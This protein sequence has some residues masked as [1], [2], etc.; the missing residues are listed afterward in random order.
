MSETTLY[1]RCDSGA[2]LLRDWSSQ[3]SFQDWCESL[4]VECHLW[5]GAVNAENNGWVSA[6]LGSWPRSRVLKVGE[7]VTVDEMMGYRP[8]AVLATPRAEECDRE[9]E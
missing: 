9:A 2:T 5:D 3:L 1:A 6:C 4:G 7:R 8:R